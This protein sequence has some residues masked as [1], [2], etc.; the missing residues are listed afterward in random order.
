MNK[1]EAINWEIEFN[2]EANAAVVT[3]TVGTLEVV[4]DFRAYHDYLGLRY[5]S[6]DSYLHGNHKDASYPTNYS[7]ANV[8]LSFGIDFQGAT[9]DWRDKV[10]KPSLVLEFTNGSFRYVT[11][12]FLGKAHEASDTHAFYTGADVPLSHSWIRWF[13]KEVVINYTIQVLIGYEDVF[14]G[15]GNYI[16][17]VPVYEEQQET[18]ENPNMDYV[19]GI[20]KYTPEIPYGASLV[21]NYFYCMADQYEI[22][23]NHLKQ[24]FGFTDPVYS[25]ITAEDVQ[26]ITLPIV[27][28]FFNP[29]NPVYTGSSQEGHVVFTNWTVSGTGA[30]LGEL[31]PV[32]QAHLFRY[33]EGYDDEYYRNPQKLVEVM[34]HLGYRESVDFYIG[35]SHFYDKNGKAPGLPS[36]FTNAVLMPD[37]GCSSSYLAWFTHYVRN[38]KLKGY[39]RFVLSVAME[40]LQLPDSWK[41]LLADGV[42]PGQT[43]WF[44]PTCFYSP[45]NPEVRAYIRKISKQQMDI[46]VAEGLK[47]ILQLGEPWW[48]WQEFMPGDVETPF[49]GRPPCFYD[50]YTQQKFTGEFGYEMPRWYNSEIKIEEGN[51]LEILNWLKEQLGDYSDF[52]KSIAAEYANSEYGILFFPPSVVD[53]ER[54]PMSM[55]IANVPIDHWKY[56]QLDYIQIEDYDW[57]IHGNMEQHKEVYSFAYNYFGYQEHLTEYFSGFV[58]QKQD[59]AESELWQRIHKAA[60]KAISYGMETYIWAGTQ[61]RRDNFTPENPMRY[62]TKSKK[63]YPDFKGVMWQLNDKGPSAKEGKPV[64]NIMDLLRL[65]LSRSS[66]RRHVQNQ[67]L[68][69]YNDDL[70]TDLFAYGW[71]DVRAATTYVLSDTAATQTIYIYSDYLYGTVLAIKY[72]GDRILNFHTGGLTKILVGFYCMTGTNIAEWTNVQLYKKDGD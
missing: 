35:A 29:S 9:L 37:V 36:G 11:L 65:Q 62:F 64:E 5:N 69:I 58:L 39:T 2:S 71:F 52:M 54:V 45:T 19:E 66:G 47:P 34:Y 8:K 53:K 50:V 13:D 61:I 10:I 46:I 68:T 6:V 24:G 26:R 63:G 57:L 43:G 56:P 48:W 3:P 14:D 27:P 7:Y 42:T 12:G 28:Y 23:F 51:N 25:D 17:T 22:D 18:V 55:R 30:Y 32:T 67:D 21:I 60:Q 59:A 1:L 16:E 49:P 15:Q 41:Q 4:A 44:P 33:A 31:P 40:N 70:A 72:P 38:L 20:L